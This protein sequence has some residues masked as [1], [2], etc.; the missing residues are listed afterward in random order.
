MTRT[1]TE[2]GVIVS[3]G[4]EPKKVGAAAGNQYADVQHGGA[5]AVRR[6]QEGKPFVGLAE[7]EE[8]AVLS[9]LETSGRPEMVLECATRLHTCMRL[10]W[11]AVCSASDAGDLEKLD[12]YC[13]RFGWLATSALRAW[14]EVR[15]EA[16]AAGTDGALDYEAILAAQRGDND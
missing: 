12:S 5:G 6:I 3:K 11:N 8:R 7:E 14:R 15:A 2:P 16:I 1:D 4:Q 9:D 13:K 10:Y